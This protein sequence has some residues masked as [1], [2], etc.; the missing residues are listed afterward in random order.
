MARKILI[1]VDDCAYTP[2]Q[3]CTFGMWNGLADLSDYLSYE[4]WLKFVL[5]NAAFLLDADI[6][7]LPKSTLLRRTGVGPKLPELAACEADLIIVTGYFANQGDLELAF[8]H[9]AHFSGKVIIFGLGILEHNG[10]VESFMRAA[11]A[12]RAAERDWG[13]W[14][15]Q[16]AATCT[17][18]KNCGFSA[19][20]LG[21]L[22]F[23]LLP[24]CHFKCA[25]E[26]VVSEVRGAALNELKT[27]LTHQQQYLN[28]NLAHK[29]RLL[30]YPPTPNELQSALIFEAKR[31][32]NHYL[33]RAAQVITASHEV[34]YLCLA[35]GIAV[36]YVPDAITSTAAQCALFTKIATSSLAHTDADGFISADCSELGL[37]QRTLL[38]SLIQGKTELSAQAIQEITQFWA[39]LEG[40]N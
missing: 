10:T 18:V 31:I 15:C 1:S 40:T 8:E 4:C 2:V 9:L 26:L 35:L 22:P 19:Q 23:M 28:F 14:Y 11:K 33:T 39:Q 3:R 38:L 29:V 36:R 34:L 6:G 25:E 37:W 20:L 27:K 13:T 7:M 12:L 16:D 30:H 32:F 17:L 24:R 5:R 21:P